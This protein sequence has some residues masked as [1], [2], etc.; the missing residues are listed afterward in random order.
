VRADKIRALPDGVRKGSGGRSAIGNLC[1]SNE[2][3]EDD[4]V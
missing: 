3:E 1:Q 2:E 4:D